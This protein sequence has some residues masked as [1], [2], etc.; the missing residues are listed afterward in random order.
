M[1]EVD[2]LV[3]GSGAG[4]LAAANRALDNGLTVKIVEKTEYWGGTSAI[5]GGALWLPVNGQYPT[6]SRAMARQYMLSCIGEGADVDRVDAYLDRVSQTVS[7][8]GSKGVALAANNEYPD[9]CQHFEGALPGGRTM[10]PQPYDGKRLGEHFHTLRD[11]LP[12]M[13]VFGRIS[14]SNPE[15]R[16][17]STRRKGWVKLL[18]SMSTAYW[19]DIPWRLKTSRG[20]RLTMGSSLVAPLGEALFKRGLRIDL[21]H[22]LRSIE[23][24]GSDFLVTLDTPEGP[25]TVVAANIILGCGGFEHNAAL[26]ARYMAEGA[27]PD[28]S[29]SPAGA[30]TGDALLSAQKLGA[31]VVNAGNAWWAPIVRG[32]MAGVEDAPYVLFMERASPGGIIVNKR[33]MR[34][35]NEAKSYNDFGLDMIADQERTGGTSD[36]WLVF[37]AGFRKRYMVGPLMAGSIQPD[38]ALPSGWLGRVIYRADSVSELAGQIGVPA[39]ALEQTVARFNEHAVDHVDPDFGRGDNVYDRYFGDANFA[40]P[41][42]AP[43][44]HGPFYAMRIMLGDLGTNG[45]LRTDRDARVL[46]A[47]GVPIE[48]LFAIGNTAASVMGQSYPGAGG[49][50]GPAVSFGIAAADAAASR[51][52]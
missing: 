35:T 1:A 15:G 21:Q 36:V 39:A 18:L 27:L 9:Y 3:V 33:G 17:L 22:R 46:D 10:D 37:D 26:R 48:G 50:L 49:T 45:G 6:D 24:D 2:V 23:R 12:F 16:L 47:R 41:N 30:N 14:L 7:F 25:K 28:H 51:H 44:A 13:K 20:S 5:S 38:K 34:F 52:H 29:A 40:N 31:A 19:F 43:L 11:Q 8:L 42:I 32:P 4:A